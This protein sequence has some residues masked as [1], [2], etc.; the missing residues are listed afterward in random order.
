MTT[1]L[2]VVRLWRCAA[3][4]PCSTEIVVP[5]CKCCVKCKN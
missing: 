3:F 1:S 5:K 4:L 2:F